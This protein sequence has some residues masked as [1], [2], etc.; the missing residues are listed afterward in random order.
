[1]LNLNVDQNTRENKKLYH[2]INKLQL[3][4]SNLTNMIIELQKK[5]ADNTIKI[6]NRNE[7]KA[8][9]ERSDE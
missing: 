3:E 9:K 5:V 4:I 8:R 1:M 6:E 7:E 2:V